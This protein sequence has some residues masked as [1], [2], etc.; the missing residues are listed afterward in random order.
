M[1][2]GFSLKDVIGNAA[3]ATREQTLNFQAFNLTTDVCLPLPT[4]TN[5][6]KLLPVYLLISLS[7]LTCGLEAYSSRLRCRIC[8]FFYPERAKERTSFLN[9]S[10]KAGRMAR[11]NELGKICFSDYI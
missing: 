7:F 11:R 5:T 6:E 10:I 8:N 4:P 1:E 2:Q 9:R 3:S